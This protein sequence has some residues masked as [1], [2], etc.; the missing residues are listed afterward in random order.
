MIL[1]VSKQR[2]KLLW[3]KFV[4]ELYF[5]GNVSSR[6]NCKPTKEPAKIS[7]HTVPEEYSK[8]NTL[9]SPFLFAFQ[10]T[11]EAA[12]DNVFS[13]VFLPSECCQQFQPL[14]IK[15]SC[16]CLHVREKLNNDI[17]HLQS[18]NGYIE[19]TPWKMHAYDF[20]SRVF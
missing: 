7:C 6:K 1:S 5:Y 3:R 13:S 9:P 20:Y 10:A 2:S 18:V 12:V 16:L 17:L 14:K 4:W 11:V 8:H 19:I 15:Y